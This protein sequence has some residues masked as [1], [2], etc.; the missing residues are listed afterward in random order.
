MGTIG[1]ITRYSRLRAPKASPPITQESTEPSFNVQPSP[2]QVDPVTPVE[3]VTPVQPI[4]PVEPVSPIEHVAPVVPSEPEKSNDS[5]VSQPTENRSNE[6]LSTLYN[7][8]GLPKEY[9][10][11]IDEEQFAE[12]IAT[13]MLSTTK[14]LMSLLNS[15]T[16]FKQESRLS[17][18]SVQPRSNNPH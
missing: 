2:V 10:A 8:L 3:R 16:V 7:K 4:A 14:G 12:D 6:F 5:I 1:H 13:V 18:T 17:L 9:L 11:S 15:R